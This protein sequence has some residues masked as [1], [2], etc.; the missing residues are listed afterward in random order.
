M[1]RL[2]GNAYYE[3]SGPNIPWR[4]TTNRN[5]TVFIKIILRNMDLFDYAFSYTTI[6]ISICFSRKTP[7]R[8]MRFLSLRRLLRKLT[9]GTYL[10]A[11]WTATSRR[12]MT[13]F[14]IHSSPKDCQNE[15]SRNSLRQQFYAKHADRKS[16][17]V[18][19]TSFRTKSP[20]PNP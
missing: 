2:R 11:F 9:S 7:R 3:E 6:K 8:R 18:W 4:F 19:G 5:F 15:V 1:G 12:L 16:P 14:C 10:Y 13:T 17:Y 20:V